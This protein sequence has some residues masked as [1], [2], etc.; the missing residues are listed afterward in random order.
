MSGLPDGF[1][2]DQ[3]AA[4]AAV[5][6]PSGFVLDQQQAPSA[7]ADLVKALPTG[8]ARG[9]IGLAG[10]PGDVRDIALS[11]LP[12]PPG[13]ATGA[14]RFVRESSVSAGS[15]AFHA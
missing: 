2:L 5:R 3:S 1:V 9:A 10:M 13:P 12:Q 7:L 6:L 14:Q 8:I 4:P 15:C 11:A